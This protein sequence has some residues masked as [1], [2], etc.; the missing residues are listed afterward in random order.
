MC[1]RSFYGKVEIFIVGEKK[2]S[3]WDWM[4]KSAREGSLLIMSCVG[5]DLGAVISERWVP[6]SHL[7]GCCPDPRSESGHR[8]VTCREEQPGS[9]LLNSKNV[10]E[11]GRGEQIVGILE[12]STVCFHQWHPES[13]RWAQDM[14]RLNLISLS[15]TVKTHFCSFSPGYIALCCYFPLLVSLWMDLERLG[16]NT[17]RPSRASVRPAPPSVAALG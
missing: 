16:V 17:R 2:K 13:M 4:W 5:S 10:Q 7:P 15:V 1:I 3:Q 6:L 11:S 9:F 12:A 14:Q 8:P